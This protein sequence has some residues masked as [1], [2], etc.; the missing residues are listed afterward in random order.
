MKIIMLSIA[1][2]SVAGFAVAATT[3]TDAFMPEATSLPKMEIPTG[4]AYG[5]LLPEDTVAIPDDAKLASSGKVLEVINSPTYTYLK[6]TSDKGPLW[7][8][9]YKTDITKGATIKY[10]RG[11]AMYRFHSKSLHRT[12]EKIIFVDSIELVME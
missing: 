7:L 3:S 4:N 5:A 12:F 11:V 2:V 10:S 9:S 8:A 6:V 1:L